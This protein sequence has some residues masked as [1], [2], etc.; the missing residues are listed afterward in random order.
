MK[1]SLCALLSLSVST[2]MAIT[3]VSTADVDAAATKLQ[4][5]I[6]PLNS[7]PVIAHPVGSCYGGGVVFY[8]SS[9]PNAPVGQRGL[10]AAPTDAQYLGSFTAAWLTSATLVSTA[11]TYFTGESNTNNIL[12][13]PG[14]FPAATA[15]RA[16]SVT[17]DTCTECTPWYLPSQ[18]ELSTMYTQSTSEINIGHT[19]FWTACGGLAPEP[20][21]YWSSTQGSAAFSFPVN[22]ATGSI[23]S[24]AANSLQR[25][26][27]VRAF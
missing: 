2:G 19:T 21:F 11:R 7:I 20:T 23:T 1:K 4:S 24:V 3:P 5:Q 25:I 8:A 14:T 17:G 15:A 12:S 16:Y 26:R 13:T 10:I 27:A 18:S 6:N 22:F 9:N